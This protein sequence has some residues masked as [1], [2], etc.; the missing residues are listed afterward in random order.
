MKCSGQARTKTSPGTRLRRNRKLRAADF[1]RPFTFMDEGIRSAGLRDRIRLL[2]RRVSGIR[3]EGNSMSPLLNSGDLVLIDPK[4][5]IEPGDVVLTRH[6]F[7]S[8]VRIVK[9]LISVEPDGRLFLEG[10]NPD[11]ST[12]SRN[13]GTVSPTDLLGKVISR[14]KT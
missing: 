1:G 12:D 5:P 8:S 14:L 9:R 4:A 11:E 6:P 3:V 13:F 10:D 2:L 7:R